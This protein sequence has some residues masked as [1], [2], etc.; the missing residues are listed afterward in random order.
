M[1][2]D[3]ARNSVDMYGSFKVKIKKTG[4]RRLKTVVKELQAMLDKASEDDPIGFGKLSVVKDQLLFQMYAATPRKY[5]EVPMPESLKESLKNVEQGLDIKLTT[6]FSP[7]EI[8]DSKK[9]IV[10]LVTMKGLKAEVELSFL[11][12]LGK[13]LKTAFRDQDNEFTQ[14]LA[15]GG[16]AFAL[17]TRFKTELTFKDFKE[18]K[19]HPMASSFVLTLDDLMK[20]LA[21]NDIQTLREKKFDISSLDEAKLQAL[22]DKGDVSESSV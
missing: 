10:E 14:G 16:P 8:V 5:F 13:T 17:S 22:V 9:S 4:A 21:R 2:A 7:Q 1:K 11:R 12:S 15:M 3:S 20:M 6:G 19:D 18:I